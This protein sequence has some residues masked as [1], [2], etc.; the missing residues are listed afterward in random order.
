M[1]DPST[2]ILLAFAGPSPLFL[3]MDHPTL[4]RVINPIGKNCRALWLLAIDLRIFGTFIFSLS[5]NFL[6]RNPRQEPQLL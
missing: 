5:A 2:A 1:A 4:P 3:L 6:D